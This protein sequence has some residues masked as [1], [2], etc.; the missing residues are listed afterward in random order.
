MSQVEKES[1]AS[2]EVCWPAVGLMLIDP[3]DGTT[4]EAAL[5]KA[6]AEAAT[7]TTASPNPTG[8]PAGQLPKGKRRR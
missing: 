3:I 8:S 5:L 6:K 7:A 4:A 2:S 1:F